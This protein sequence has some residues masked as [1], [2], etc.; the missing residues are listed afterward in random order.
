[1]YL[2]YSEWRE[3]CGKELPFLTEQISP[4]FLIPS[5]IA[6][7]A[8]GLIEKNVSKVR[9]ISTKNEVPS[10]NKSKV[11]NLKSTTED[12]SGSWLGIREKVLFTPV[13]ITIFF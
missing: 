12:D 1:M 7:N 6:L 11:W 9:T 8:R 13:S 2:L 10:K 4:P 5:I 3:Y